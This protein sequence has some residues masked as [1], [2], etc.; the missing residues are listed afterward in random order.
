MKEKMLWVM[1]LH[2]VSLSNPLST[3]AGLLTSVKDIELCCMSLNLSLGNIVFLCGGQMMDIY[4]VKQ[5]FIGWFAACW[6]LQW[7]ACELGSAGEITA[8]R[9]VGTGE[10]L[11]SNCWQ[12]QCVTHQESMN[13]LRW[14]LCA[15]THLPLS[16]FCTCTQTHTQALKWVICM[17]IIS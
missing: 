3:A 4:W 11:L 12:P 8:G 14:R 17:S 7:G 10:R 6:G 9:W 13:E 15:H 2:H 16:I 5:T 1:W